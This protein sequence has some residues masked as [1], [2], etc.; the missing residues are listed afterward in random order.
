MLSDLESRQAYL[1]EKNG[2]V[3][4]GLNQSDVYEYEDNSRIRLLFIVFVLLVLIVS[5]FGISNINFDFDSIN[6]LENQ[7]ENPVAE[8]STVESVQN[9]FVS[10]VRSIDR[11]EKVIETSS[12]VHVKE[13]ISLPV[14]R[15]VNDINLSVKNST[16]K[17]ADVL[18]INEINKHD[19]FTDI[20]LSIPVN[21]H[22]SL[23]TL[24]S[25]SRLVLS[26]DEFYPDQPYI[27]ENEQPE[28]LNIRSVQNEDGEFQ[29]VFEFDHEISLEN[30]TLLELGNGMSLSIRL[31]EPEI[32]TVNEQ[33][34][35]EQPVE[36]PSE[37]EIVHSEV[38]EVILDEP[39]LEKTI[40]KND[41]VRES[42]DVYREGKLAIESG[43]VINAID[44]LYSAVRLDP[45]NQ[46]ARVALIEI[47]LEQGDKTAVKEILSVGLELKPSHVNMAKIMA[48]IL[49]EEGNNRLA[50]L[51]L[52]RALPDVNQDPE[53]HALVAA[54]LQRES[55]H[56]EAI[57]FYRNVLSV[58]TGN[59]IWWM[60]L[61]ISLEATGAGQQALAAYHRARQD[62][63]I[64]SQIASYLDGRIN[65]LNQ[66]RAS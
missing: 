62:N 7:K 17:A 3:F 13:K 11:D 56:K 40:R 24:E 61:G 15:L 31:L 37:N 48:Q 29:L 43:E 14:L 52:E 34:F 42:D 35:V 53:Y 57:V 6:I 54:L 30:T 41:Q 51:Y 28:W 16:D 32:V 38:P 36:L 12:E 55:R 26:L 20:K 50:L 46:R 10:S 8:S 64:S 63:N 9:G 47:L 2:N 33:L 4:D 19:S 1:D 21:T 44:K 45:N 58:N 25:P 23:F 18:T 66:R 65:R 27:F 39:R 22:Y 5:L 60:G 49:A 59:G